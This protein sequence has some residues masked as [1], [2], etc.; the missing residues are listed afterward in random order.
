[1]EIEMEQMNFL[2]L[3]ENLDLLRQVKLLEEK[4]NN[5]RRGIFG[6][7]DKVVSN[8]HSMEEKLNLIMHH[9]ELEKSDIVENKIVNLPLFSQQN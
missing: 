8:V 6:R 2:D 5:L 3:T 1:M 7:F 9:L 4:Q